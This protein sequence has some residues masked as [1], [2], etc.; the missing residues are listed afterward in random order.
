MYAPF[1]L[2]PAVTAARERLCAVSLPSPRDSVCTSAAYVA[3]AV[4]RQGVYIE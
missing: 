4:A 1:N 2:V 3:A